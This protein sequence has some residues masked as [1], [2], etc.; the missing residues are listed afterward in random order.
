MR[1]NREAITKD[2]SFTLL[3]R[4]SYLSVVLP[5]PALCALALQRDLPSG[6]MATG[7]LYTCSVLAAG[8]SS[9]AGDRGGPSLLVFVQ[10]NLCS[11]GIRDECDSHSRWSLAIGPV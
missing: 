4:R 9:R 5:G 10:F 8:Q 1:A 7:V 11:P 6:L 2:G 3:W